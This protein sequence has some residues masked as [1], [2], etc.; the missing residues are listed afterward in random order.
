[1]ANTIT[2]DPS[3]DPQALAEAEARDGESLAQG[4]KM[5]Q[6]QS[7]LLAGKYKDAEELEK[8]Y[9]ELQQKLGEGETSQPESD[10]WEAVPGK[11]GYG[12]DG[13]VD[14]DTVEEVYGEN[15]AAVF[16]D[17]N[18]DPWEISQHFHNNNGTITDDMYQNLQK[19][20]IPKNAV[21]S[22]L[23]GR[24]SEMGYTGGGEALSEGDVNDMYNLAGG[25]ETY[26]NMTEWAAQN[27]SQ[28]DIAAFDEVT[29]TGNKAAVRFAVK[30]LIGQYEDAQGRTPELVTGRNARA[31]TTYR[32]MAEVVR[33]MESPQ[34][35]KDEAYRFDV[36]QKLERSNLK[37]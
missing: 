9:I 5:V 31:G 33:D 32:S 2:Y 26:D 18:L 7:E 14:Y 22:Y 16:E 1:M 36:M 13:N 27:M 12:E 11:S 10:N 23:A 3:E 21:D 28:D 29:N 4:E 6:E 34:Y 8:A 35:E 24:A 30:A 20:G 19:A 37:V 25:K 15:L 17:A